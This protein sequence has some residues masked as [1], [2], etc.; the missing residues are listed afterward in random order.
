[1]RVFLETQRFA[2]W[3]FIVPLLLLSG[4]L[5]SLITNFSNWEKNI[6]LLPSIGVFCLLILLLL[7]SR[8][9]TRIDR[10]G[11]ETWFSPLGFPKKRFSWNEIEDCY[12]HRYSNGFMGSNKPK[13]L[14]GFRVAGKDG[15]QIVTK[16]NKYFLLGTQKPMHVKRTINYYKND[17]E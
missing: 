7:V 5:L 3:I 14:K 10:Y 13:L 12:I 9:H 4:F 15:I 17:T 2:W 1:M 11:I 8:L 16:S 6:I